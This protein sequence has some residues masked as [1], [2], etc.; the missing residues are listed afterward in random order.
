MTSLFNEGKKNPLIFTGLHKYVRHPLYLGTFI[1]IWGLFVLFPLLS[2][3]IADIVI[4]IYTLIGINFEEEKLISD[5]GKEYTRYQNMV[6]KII[7]FSKTK[8]KK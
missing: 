5:F 2:L 8:R 1:F 3:L 7:P 4:T 6:P